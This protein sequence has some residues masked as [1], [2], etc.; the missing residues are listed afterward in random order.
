MSY[1][2]C[3][4]STPKRKVPVLELRDISYRLPNN[5][6]VELF[7]KMQFK[8]FPGEFVLII[9]QNGAGK[10]TGMA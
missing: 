4:S 10:S 7:K 9:G 8:I 3:D 5:F 1:S 6:D 2:C